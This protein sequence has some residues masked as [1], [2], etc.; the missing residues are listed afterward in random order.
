MERIKKLNE[1]IVRGDML[2]C[3]MHTLGGK[4]SSIIMPDGVETPTE[5][6]DYMEV[7]A[8]G[9]NINDVIEGDIVVYASTS[10]KGFTIKGESYTNVVRHLCEVIVH[11]DNFNI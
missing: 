11:K 6:I 10:G 8:V 3:K 2:F 5:S 4:K 7:I 1:T 9:K